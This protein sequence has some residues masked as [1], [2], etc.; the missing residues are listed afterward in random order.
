[1]DLSGSHGSYYFSVGQVLLRL[2]P[3]KQNQRLSLQSILAGINRLGNN[4]FYKKVFD[5]KGSYSQ[6]YDFFSSSH[7]WMSELDHKEG[8]VSEN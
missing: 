3:V 5:D 8:Q 4:H 2:V 7:V 6:S 1:M